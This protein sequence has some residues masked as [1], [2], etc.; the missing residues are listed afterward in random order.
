MVSRTQRSLANASLLRWETTLPGADAHN[1]PR[2]VAD[3]TVSANERALAEELA[4]ESYQYVYV[5]RLCVVRWTQPMVAEDFDALVSQLLV[6]SQMGEARFVLLFIPS[7]EG[8]CPA[9]QRLE[10]SAGTSASRSDL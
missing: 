3:V 9:F 7:S 8:S 5:G 1:V 2:E 10:T 6:A 4:V